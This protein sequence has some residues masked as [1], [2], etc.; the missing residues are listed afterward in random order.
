M[1]DGHEWLT[2][3]CSHEP[4]P[5][6]P[7]DPDGQQLEYFSQ[8]EPAFKV[9]QKLVFDQTWLFLKYQVFMKVLLVK[10]YLDFFRHT[11]LLESFNNVVL[12]YAPKGAAFQYAH[13]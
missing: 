10:I 13:T 8:H 2:G 3:A 12:A 9:F 4:P 6:P 11:G 1:I 5:G 7:K